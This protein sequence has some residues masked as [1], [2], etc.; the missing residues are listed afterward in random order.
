MYIFVEKRMLKFSLTLLTCFMIISCARKND[1]KYDVEVNMD[2][3]IKNDNDLILYYKDGS[4]DWFVDD[5]AVWVFAKGSQNV[6]SI[7]FKINLSTLPNDFRLD[8]G[9]NE[10]KNK[11]SIQ[12]KKFVLRY[13]DNSLIIPE[14]KFATYFK[15]NQYVK[16][17]DMSKSYIL[18]KGSDGKYDP[19]FEATEDFY[20]E[21]LKLIN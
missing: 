21:L 12:I 16:Y 1:K 4:N 7:V 9:R 6:Q 18:D 17:D 8:I 2:V 13:N 19:F 15:G 5:K 11:E 10:F 14:D 3:T 20:P